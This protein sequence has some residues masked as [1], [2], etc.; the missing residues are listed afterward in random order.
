MTTFTRRIYRCLSLVIAGLIFFFGTAPIAAAPDLDALIKEDAIRPRGEF[1][2][3]E[4]PD[5]LDLA[6]RAKLAVNVLTGNL[7]PEK[8]YCVL[9]SFT[10]ANPPVM[11]GQT[12]NLPAKNARSLPWMRTMCG[13]SL[14]LDIEANLMRALVSAIRKDGLAYVPVDNDGAPKDTAYPVAN[15]LFA[16]ALLNWHERDGHPGWLELAGTISE[17][18][19]RI[20]IRIEDRAYYPPESSY[21]GEGNWAW[22]TRGEAKIPYQP[23]EEPYLEQQGLEGCV[24]YEQAGA[25][26][27]VV[28]DYRRNPDPQKRELL[29]CFRRF[30]LKPGL[31]E[32]TQ[33][34]GYPGNEHGIFAGHFHGNVTSIH[35]LL[36]LAIATDNDSLKQFVREAYGYARRTGVIRMGWFPGW[37]HPQEH[38]RPKTLYLA[39]ETCG[40]SDM[41]LLAVKLTDAGLG[42]YWDDVDAIARNHLIAQQITD[43]ER[44]RVLSGNNPE[45]EPMLKRFLGGFN[46]S[47]EGWVN[48][49]GPHSWGC[50]TANGTIGLYYAWHGITRFEKDTATINLLLNRSS[51]WLDID[52]FLPYEGKVVIYN[53]KAK[54]IM[55]RLPF[56]LKRDTLEVTIDK[57]K[58]I[59]VIVD[60]RLL[61]SGLRKTS[62]VNLAFVVPQ[63]T[64]SYNIGERKY[65]LLLRGSTVIDITPR[66]ENPDMYQY[67]VRDHMLK[68]KAPTKKALRFVADKVLPLQ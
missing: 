42:D 55:V 23:P 6:E 51:A 12:W 43:V 5:T 63:V 20:A 28:A 40:V 13:S 26:R 8:S 10:F 47:M 17:A 62:K 53:K 61:L 57:K 65:D 22:T 27:A 7:D 41:L 14:N 49:T 36:E 35:A 9:Q 68:N 19:G 31:W 24:K 29:N 50:C 18:L 45:N 34:K 58:I 64:E 3:R 11:G 38:H 52:S 44:M 48:S 21:Q 15:G 32:D 39:S 56:W 2:E 67:Y 25:V 30:L 60:N 66:D 4:V 33:D 54:T 59:P 1:Y 37:L 46:Q 16:L